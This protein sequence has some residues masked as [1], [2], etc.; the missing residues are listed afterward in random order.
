MRRA[1]VDIGSNTVRLLVLDDQ[2]RDLER[3]YVVTGLGRGVDTSRSF[4][5]DSVAHTLS[6]LGEYREAMDRLGVAAMRA[7]ATSATRDVADGQDFL[8]AAE[9]V[10]GVRPEVISGEEEAA[11]SF[12]GGMRGGREKPPALVIDVGGGSTEF[13]YGTD[14]PELA[15][16]IDMG[17]VRLTD[18][19]LPDRPACPD[20]VAAARAEAD[21]AFADVGLRGPIGTAVGVGGTFTTLVTLSRGLPYTADVHGEVLTGRDLKVLIDTLARLT[22]EGTAALDGIDPARAPI[23][24]GGAIAVERAMAASGIDEIVVSE[25]DLL[26]GIALSIDG[27]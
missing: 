19:A 17:S 3:R 2:G 25:H 9:A 14:E 13:V 5:A 7:V 8:D 15:T 23:V 4:R 24:L 26:D 11:L 27:S 10:L 12:H 6:A 16:S 1:A 20:Q 21:R 22:I 18:R